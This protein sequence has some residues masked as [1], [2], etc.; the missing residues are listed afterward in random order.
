MTARE[1]PPTKE[2]AHEKLTE[3]ER[4]LE[5]EKLMEEARQL[6]RDYLQ[7]LKDAGA[8]EL[9]DLI[10]ELGP[11]QAL[12]ILRGQRRADSPTRRWRGHLAL[13]PPARGKRAQRPQSYIAFYD[14][15]EVTQALREAND[16]L[17]LVG[18]AELVWPG[19]RL[20]LPG[21]SGGL[22]VVWRH[23]DM[24]PGD[25]L[26]YC[27][28]SLRHRVEHELTPPAIARSRAAARLR[29]RLRPLL[30]LDL[31]DPDAASDRS[32]DGTPDQRKRE[33]AEAAR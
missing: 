30:V 7:L 6:E 9:L 23:A 32:I 18:A 10:L 8:A 20:F 19:P 31:E 28:D 16:E 5:R 13:I 12:E 1:S 24:A 27:V 25:A 22:A 33:L 4:R 11:A 29:K 17:G 14:L 21:R 26:D 15:D 3:E 2:N